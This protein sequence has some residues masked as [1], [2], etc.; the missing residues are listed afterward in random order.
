MTDQSHPQRP[1][2]GVFLF[3]LWGPLL[4][5]LHLLVVYVS[6]AGL[7]ALGLIDQTTTFPVALAIIV[8]ATVGAAAAVALFMIWPDRP[9]RLLVGIAPTA[10]T[11]RFLIRSM[12]VLALLS[13]VGILWAGITAFILP[14]CLQLR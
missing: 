5:S 1:M 11:D 9:Y 6:H 4:W 3:L 14:A 8:L 13:V 10:E 12:R 2:L 7:C